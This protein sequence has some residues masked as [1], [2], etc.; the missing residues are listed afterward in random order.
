MIRPSQGQQELPVVEIRQALI[1]SV[2]ADQLSVGLVLRQDRD[3]W[4]WE[5]VIQGE[6][7]WHRRG[8]SGGDERAKIPDELALEVERVIDR[9]PVYPGVEAVDLDLRQAAARQRSK[10]L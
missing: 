8:L 3:N 2:D 7:P 5:V 1:D 6:E 9:L 4:V 10:R